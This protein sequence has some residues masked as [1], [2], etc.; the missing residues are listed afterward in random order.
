MLMEIL[1]GLSGFQNLITSGHSLGMRGSPT[2]ERLVEIVVFAHL[3]IP[4]IMVILV[5]DPPLPPHRRPSGR[6]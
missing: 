5:P 6:L 2:L 4:V 3:I 1:V